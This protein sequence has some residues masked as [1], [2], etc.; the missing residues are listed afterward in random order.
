MAYV[1]RRLMVGSR[2]GGRIRWRQNHLFELGI[3]YREVG[4][5]LAPTTLSC[6]VFADLLIRKLGSR[7][8]IA[9]WLPSMVDGGALGTVA[10]CET[11]VERSATHMATTAE[12]FDGGWRLNGP[13]PT[14]QMARE[15]TWSWCR[16]HRSAARPRCHRLLRSATWRRR[17]RHRAAPHPQSRCP[18]HPALGER[19]GER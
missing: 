9:T 16:P 17:R 6:T 8:Q 3:A 2:V 19:H 4:R 15:P 12:Q 13:R 10:F 7:E 1:R 11:H 14:C 5:T 18:A